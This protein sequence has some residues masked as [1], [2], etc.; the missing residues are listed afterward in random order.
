MKNLKYIL[1]VAFF[2]FLYGVG[3][4]V[5]L[6]MLLQWTLE[7]D[8]TESNNIYR[9]LFLFWGVSA[10]GWHLYHKKQG[11]ERELDT[12]PMGDLEK[13]DPDKNYI[14]YKKRFGD[15]TD[16]QFLGIFNREVGNSGWTSSR[17]S[18]LVALRE[19]FEKRKIVVTDK[20]KQPKP[21]AFIITTG[22]GQK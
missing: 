11:K 6:S 1:A 3:F 15:M 18:Y 7:I 8:I 5:L 4:L 22:G 17:A 10:V 21:R 19:E 16:E 9:L 12:K 2:G 13:S 14:E 20:N